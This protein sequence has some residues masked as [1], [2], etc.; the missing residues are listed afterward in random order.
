MV[1]SGV[2]RARFAS[3]GT[4]LLQYFAD[5]VKIAAVVFWTFGELGRTSWREIA[6]IAVVAALAFVYFLYNRWNYNALESG[7]HSAAS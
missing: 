1:L 3:G 6:I 2:A 7:E 4:T 5:D